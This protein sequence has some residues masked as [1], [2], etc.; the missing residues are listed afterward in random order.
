MGLR[1]SDRWLWDFWLARTG[2]DYHLFFLQA[3]RALGDPERRHWH[4]SVG[5]AVS[6]DLRSWTLLPDALRPSPEGSAAF[7]SY[8]TWTGSVIRHAGLWYLFYTGGRRDEEGK[9]QRV[10]L[11]TST[12]LLRWDKHPANP[13]LT[14]DPTWYELLDLEHWHEQAWRDPYVIRHPTEEAFYALVTARADHGPPDGRGVIGLARSEDLIGWQVLPPVTQP[15]EFGHLEVPQWVALQ[16]RYHLLF[17]VT[18]DMESERRRAR[19]R[20]PPVTGTYVMSADHPLGPFDVQEARLLVGDEI[21]S[22]YAGKLVQGP[23]GRWYFL[24]ALMN[25]PQGDF[26]GELCDP[27]PVSVSSDGTLEVDVTDQGGNL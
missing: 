5:H 4:V 21:G 20:R 27:F 3:P 19:S 8:T 23:R 15:G 25:G 2:P 16:G 7:D 12:D 22:Y 13:L 14:P 17:C 1:L 9:I 10:G 11:A 24:A 18:G 26:V 6:Q